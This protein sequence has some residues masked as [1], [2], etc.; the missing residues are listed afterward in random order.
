MLQVSEL[1]FGKFRCCGKIGF[2]RTKILCLRVKAKDNTERVQPI[3]YDAKHGLT[4]LRNMAG[5]ERLL[6]MKYINWDLS[7]RLGKNLPIWWM[8]MTSSM[9]AAIFLGKYNSEKLHS[10]RITDLKL[11]AQKLFDVT[12][13][14]INWKKL[15]LAKDYR[16]C[17]RL[18]LFIMVITPPMI[19]GKWNVYFHS[20]LRHH[21]RDQ[22]PTGGAVNK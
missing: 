8:F 9:H 19:Y 4:S 3:T 20:Q 12:Q 7:H 15:S 16:L 22:E 5:Y 13:G 21:R 10:V 1:H 6:Q 11:T 18:R 14:F 17:H 2:N